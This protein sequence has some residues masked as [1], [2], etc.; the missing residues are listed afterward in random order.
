MNCCWAFKTR[1]GLFKISSVGSGFFAASPAL[2]PSASF[3]PSFFSSMELSPSPAFG[4]ASLAGEADEVAATA[5][6]SSTSMPT[7]SPATLSVATEP[8]TVV[9]GVAATDA[10]VPAIDIAPA[11]EAFSATE[12]LSS[13]STSPEEVAFFSSASFSFFSFRAFAFDAVDST[14][15]E[16]FTCSSFFGGCIGSGYAKHEGLMPLLNWKFFGI[17]SFSVRP[18][19]AFGVSTRE[20]MWISGNQNHICENRQK[21]MAAPGR[22]TPDLE[23]K[24]AHELRPPASMMPFARMA[25]KRVI[26]SSCLSAMVF[27]SFSRKALTRSVLPAEVCMYSKPMAMMAACRTKSVPSDIKGS[28][29]ACAS[30]CA[31]PAQA[32]PKAMAAA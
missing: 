24:D 23:K 7:S 10:C 8:A 21:P 25:P 29:R 6:C 27:K 19:R 18:M 15:V 17:L 4:V 22:N 1:Q 32:M 11:T 13:I 30:A 9:P 28:K 5:A 14:A 26:T 20:N 2:S 31:L 12:P 3:S 16:A